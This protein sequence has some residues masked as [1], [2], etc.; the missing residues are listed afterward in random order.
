[1]LLTIAYVIAR[2]KQ[3]PFGGTLTRTM[4]KFDR[5]LSSAEDSLLLT[6]PEWKS[7]KLL[8]VKNKKFGLN[9]AYWPSD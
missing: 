2:K 1:M 9:L 5:T 8:F 4:L 6:K 3:L 7:V